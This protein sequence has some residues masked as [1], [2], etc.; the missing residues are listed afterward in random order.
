MCRS[1]SCKYIRALDICVHDPSILYFPN[2]SRGNFFFVSCFEV[3]I[4]VGC[5]VW[6]MYVL[7]VLILGMLL[8]FHHLHM[9]KDK[10]ILNMMVNLG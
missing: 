3:P 4:F 8:W 5:S 6:R 9:H 10:K 1:L 2:F 7:L